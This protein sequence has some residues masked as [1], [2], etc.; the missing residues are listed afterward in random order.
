MK[1]LA[2]VD[3]VVRTLHTLTPDRL[4]E[5]LS[6]GRFKRY[7][8]IQM[9]GRK[10]AQ[11][12]SRGNARLVISIP[13]R[14]G[15]SWLISKWLPVWDLTLAPADNIILSSYEADFA[16]QWGRQV[17]NL[18]TENSDKLQIKLTEDSKAANR[19]N[20]PEGGG[21]VTAG[22]GGP[23]TGR[24]GN[25]L[26]IDD[27]VKNWEQAVSDVYQR[28]TIDWFN[29]TLYT[30]AEPNASIIL[31]MT[32]WH[33]NDLAGYL[34]S[35]HE[36]PWEE[37]RLPA[38]AEEG[39]PLERKIGEAL[40]PERYKAEDLH[41]IKLA[42]G[43]K[44]FNSLYQQRPTL[45]EGNIIKRQWLK[46]YMHA[47]GFERTIIT[48]DA[49]FTKKADS[50]FVVLQTWGRR[51]S[52]KYHL[53]QIRDRMGITETIQALKS[54][55]AKWPAA[56]LKLI[57]N[58]ANGPAIEDL[59]KKELSGIVLWEPQGD[60]VSRAN[61][62]APQYEAGNVYYPHPSIAPWVNDLVEE[63][64]SFPNGSH[65]DQVDAMTMALIRLEEDISHGVGRMRVIR[66]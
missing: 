61:A 55:S 33:Q 37:I 32:R 45:E 22:I 60:K 2:S 4:A 12:I 62:V 49:T 13:P 56:T 19:W 47:S 23:I 38:L 53:D 46:F 50:D 25:L 6:K 11:S 18:I 41:K 65:D 57:E 48:L 36:D 35:E 59:L 28:K 16:S 44:M 9:L 26:I 24:G 29:S 17:R 8:H 1:S 5:D 20:T 30:R 64:V 14:H 66:R 21:M 51:G 34:L 15:K 39:D 63:V 27:P 58:K 43:S 52:E 7:K 40:C 31:L 42:V 3:G 54:L 10:L